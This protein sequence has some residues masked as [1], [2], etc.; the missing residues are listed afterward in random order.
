MSS[1]Y[2]AKVN[3]RDFRVEVRHLD[4]GGLLVLKV[5]AETFTLKASLKEDGTWTV[6]DTK[7]DHVLK[8]LRRSGKRVVVDVDGQQREVEWER[9][10]KEE[11]DRKSGP[12]P[13]SGKRVSGGVYPPMPGKVTEVRVS[14]GD[15][16][17]SGQTV[18]ILEAMKMF[19]ELKAPNSGTVRQIN[20]KPGSPVALGDLLILIE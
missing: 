20:V 3:G 9:V 2:E 15:K 1:E 4:E 5:G 13:K 10:R 19:N 7:S 12:S 17:E 18:C 8:L 14:V 6:N 11:T 16:I